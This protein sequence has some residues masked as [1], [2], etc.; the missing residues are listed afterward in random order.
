MTNEEFAIEVENSI[1]RSKNV[2]IKKGKEYSGEIDRL[3]NFK[4]AGA[5]QNILPTEALYSMAMKHIISIANMV[6]KPSEFT[7]QQWYEK[8][9]DLRNYTILLEALLLDG[10][11]E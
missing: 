5:A 2:L 3:E 10:N 7:L 4:R 6:S 1:N 9:G 8:T 11:K